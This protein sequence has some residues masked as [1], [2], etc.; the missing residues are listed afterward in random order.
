MVTVTEPSWFNATVRVMLTSPWAV[1][2]KATVALDRVSVVVIVTLPRL[3]RVTVVGVVPE[4]STAA[5]AEALFD[6]WRDNWAV[7]NCLSASRFR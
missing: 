1:G 3:P 7:W 6:P 5:W 2:S 4:R